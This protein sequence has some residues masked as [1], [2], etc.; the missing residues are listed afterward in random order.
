VGPDLATI[1]SRADETVI[2]DV[3]DP[4][5][6]LTVGYQHYTVITTDGRIFTGILAAETA[7]GI[8]LRKEEGVEETILRRDVEEMAASSISMMP[9]ELE[10]EVTPR[11][12]VDLIAYLRETLGPATPGKAILFDDEPEFADLLTDGSGTASLDSLDAFAGQASLAIGPPQRFASRIPTWAYR[13]CENPQPGEFR[14]LRFAWKARGARGLMIELAADGQW[15]SA[16]EPVRRYYCGQNTSGW[17]ALELA[18]EAPGD[19]VVV[20]RDLWKDFGPFTLTGIAP[21]AMGGEGLFDR[22]ELLQSLDAIPR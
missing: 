16:D 11:D 1:T 8:S 6:Q 17:Q 14:Y 4:S 13:I 22:I 9:E 19:W 21:T 18:S 20:T 3:L 15:P 2:A 7:T 5:R 12:L 10:K